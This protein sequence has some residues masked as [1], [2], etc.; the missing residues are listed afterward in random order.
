M[1]K[2]KGFLRIVSILF[3][4][5]ALAFGGVM[6]YR[7]VG[8]LP[9]GNGGNNSSTSTLSTPKNVA[10]DGEAYKLT[11]SAVEHADS[12]KVDINGKLYDATGFEYA[13][14]PSQ[15]VNSFKVQA[16]DTTGNYK[17]SEWS[18]A[19]QHTV[20]MDE[21]LTPAAIN[22]FASKAIGKDAV[23]IVSIYSDGAAIVINAV[24]NEGRLQT[25]EY[26]YDH[27][28]SSLNE[29]MQNNEYTGRLSIG[30]HGAKNYD[31]AGNYLSLGAYK[32]TLGEYK[33]DGY[34]V[35]VVTSQ[36]YE[37]DNTAIGLV[38]VFKVTKGDETKY[39]ASMI[40]FDLPATAE[41]SYRYTY[42]VANINLSKVYEAE[43]V[44]LQGDFIDA[45][46]LY[47][48]GFTKD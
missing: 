35:S 16:K 36:A 5:A 21:G 42:S 3:L 38:A 39:L 18:E 20:K 29:T 43:C 24:D 32:G 17:T 33:N 12:Y 13:Y 2:A 46:A 47:A 45:L 44:E 11:W 7:A 15:E 28:V 6:I 22:V 30:T 27:S 40:L 41:D 26:R 1:S 4:V 8:K 31:T 37:V 14:V 25:C 48:D 19:V 9:K 34:A 23:K 10:Y